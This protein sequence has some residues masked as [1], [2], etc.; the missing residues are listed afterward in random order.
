[1]FQKQQIKPEKTRT[2]PV[3][4]LNLPPRELSE[5]DES[6]ANHHCATAF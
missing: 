4:A 2:R 5:L 6:L 3:D 1:M